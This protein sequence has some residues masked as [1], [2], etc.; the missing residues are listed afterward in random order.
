MSNQMNLYRC[1]VYRKRLFSALLITA[2]FTPLAVTAGIY[3]WTDKDGNIHYGSQRPT[4]ITSEQMKIQPD[5]PY[6][7]MNAPKDTKKELGK[8]NEKEKKPEAVPPKAPE[9]PG[10]SRK[11][12]KRLCQQA[13]KNLQTIESRGR[14]RVKTDDGSTRH[15]TDQERSKQLAAVR[16]NVS[17]YCK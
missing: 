9:K 16:K 12:K 6:A 17:K 2:I 11:E 3:K 5:R 10:L 4:D 15:L 14:V 7:D 13:R 1:S 8:E